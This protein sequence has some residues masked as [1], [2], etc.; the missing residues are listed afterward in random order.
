MRIARTLGL[1]LGLIILVG[2]GA[3]TFSRAQQ[4]AEKADPS[5]SGRAQLRERVI[6]LR[7]EVDVLQVEFRRARANLAKAM[8]L[9]GI[10]ELTT[11]DTLGAGALELRGKS[12]KETS[13]I[14]ERIRSGGADELKGVDGT[15]LSQA[16]ADLAKGEKGAAKE[17]LGILKGFQN[18]FAVLVDMRKSEFARLSTELNRKKLDLAEAE[19]QYQNETETR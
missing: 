10:T 8:E 19:K 18:P 14:I 3:A 16:V 6:T 13:E 9:V 7:T 4:T 2:V 1:G 17:L 15:K 11:F 5:A 12:D